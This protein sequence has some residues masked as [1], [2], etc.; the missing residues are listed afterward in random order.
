MKILLA[1]QGQYEWF[2]PA[3]AEGLRRLGQEIRFF[4]WGPFFPGGILGK[5]EYKFMWGPAVRRTNLELRRAARLFRPEL[6]LIHCGFPIHPKTVSDLASFCWVTGFHHDDPFGVFGREPYF[7]L[8]RQAIPFYHSHHVIREENVSDYRRLGVKKVRVIMRYYV[9][10]LHAL[11]PPVPSG[12]GQKHEVVFIGHP[13]PDHRIQYM[14]DLVRA[15]IPLRLFGS[16][17]WGRYLPREI[18]RICASQSP[19]LLGN[20][21]AAMIS[22]SKICI[23]FHSK[24]NRDRYS[25]RVFEIPACGGFLLAERT[26]IMQ[27]LYEEGREAEYFASS[28]ELMDKTRFYLNHEEARARIARRG[29]ERCLRSGYD[30]VSRMKEWL[31]D[32]ER[33]RNN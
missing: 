12:L 8:F 19:P 11:Q 32:I 3:W 23:A 21:Y 1:G 6:L 2:A 10:W 31:S 29:H 27:G 20:A 7:R 9:P 22:S 4:D 17:Q 25:Y 26:D 28:E 15:K 13:E 30:V 16:A 33:F 5:M 18:A 14:I 24:A